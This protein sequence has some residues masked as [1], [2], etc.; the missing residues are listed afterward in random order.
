MVIVFDFF[1]PFQFM[2]VLGDNRDMVQV[3]CQNSSVKAVF[4]GEKSS[5]TPLCTNGSQ[6]YLILHLRIKG[7]HCN[8]NMTL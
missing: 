1:S 8:T 3:A 6:K 2:A 5:W 7:F 4:R